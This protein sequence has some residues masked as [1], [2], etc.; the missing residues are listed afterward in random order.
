MLLEE[1]VFFRLTADVFLH[2]CKCNAP[3]LAALAEAQQESSW[4]FGTKKRPLPLFADEAHDIPVNGN[5]K[6]HK[7]MQDL[8]IGGLFRSR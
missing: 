1:K 3:F 8:K 5:G 4:R 7:Q 6:S 2:P